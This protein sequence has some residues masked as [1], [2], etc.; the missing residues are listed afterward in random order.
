MSLP[1][2]FVGIAL[3]T[4]IFVYGIGVKR[5]ELSQ[6]TARTLAADMDRFQFVAIHVPKDGCPEGWVVMR[7]GFIQKNGSL[8]DACVRFGQGSFD[9][10]IDYLRPGESFVIPVI[11]TGASKS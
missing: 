4:M 11:Q 8:E 5:S 3:A 6:A 2:A 7:G 9:W 10:R 1:A